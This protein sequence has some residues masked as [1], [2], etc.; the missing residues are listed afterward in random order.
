MTPKSLLR[1]KRCVSSL[2]EMGS[3]TAFHRVM[4]E[5][6]PSD[7]DAQVER[8]ILCTGKVYYD[9]LQAREERGLDGKVAL[10]RLEELA[11]FPEEALESE[12]KRYAKDAKF[13]W[14][15]E[16]P[17]N[18]GAW[19]FV[20]PRIENLMEAV[21][22]EQ[23]RLAYAGRRPSASPATGYHAQHEREQRQLVEDAL[24]A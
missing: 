4:Y 24:S 2:S 14:C 20:A 23:R 8:V 11:P 22:I 21:G 15:Q 18:M 5:A 3:G 9:L 19:F 13:V 17:R 10:I 6:P 1:H 16:E 12:L 7:T